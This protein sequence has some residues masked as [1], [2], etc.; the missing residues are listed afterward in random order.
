MSLIWIT[1]NCA[2]L[3]HGGK[4]VLEGPGGRR[5]VS[6]DDFWLSY[7]ATA[8]QINELAVEVILPPVTEAYIINRNI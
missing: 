3:A 5:E 1:C 7:M 8:R 2:I 6:I 4:S